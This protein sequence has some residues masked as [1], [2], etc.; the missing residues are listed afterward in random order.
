MTKKIATSKRSYT[1]LAE[2][3]SR[4]PGT[5]I[6][7]E[8]TDGHL[9]NQKRI[10][11]SIVFTFNR[12]FYAPKPAANPVSVLTHPEICVFFTAVI[13]LLRQY[14]L[15]DIQPPVLRTK[16]CS[17]SRVRADSS[18]RDMRVVHCCNWLLRQYMLVDIQPPVLILHSR[19]IPGMMQALLWSQTA[20]EKYY[21][22]NAAVKRLIR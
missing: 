20:V 14:M 10:A 12:S 1:K 18:S 17:K 16:T 22:A 19:D 11:H 5:F 3:G 8:V 7:V 6:L 9:L 13:G 4:T 21:I 2:C 15:V